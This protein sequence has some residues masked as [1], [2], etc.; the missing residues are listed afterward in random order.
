MLTLAAVGAGWSTELVD[1][2][3]DDD[4]GAGVA[5]GDGPTRHCANQVCGR[6][7]R[8]WAHAKAVRRCY[9]SGTG[10]ESDV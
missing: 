7:T 8:L 4:E 10:A 2:S 6:R 1:L 3:L 5:P 9:A